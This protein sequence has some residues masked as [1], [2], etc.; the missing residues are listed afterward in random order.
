M[1]RGKYLA[2]A[3]LLISDRRRYRELILSL[4]NYYTKQQRNYLRTITDMYGIIVEFEPT[5]ATAVAGGRKKGLNFGNMFAN[6]EGTGDGDHVGGGVIG[7]KLECWKCGGEH[8]KKNSPKHAKEKEKSK[9]DDD[10]ADD[11][12]ADGKTD[13]RGVQLNTMFTSLVDVQSGTDFSDLGEDE[14]FNWNKLHVEGWGE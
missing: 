12:R 7:I 9:K 2:A 1:A 4:K 11:R 13:V 6:S 8:L 3:F 5:R 14:E 10:G